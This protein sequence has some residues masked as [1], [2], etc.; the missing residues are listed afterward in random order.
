MMR[1]VPLNRAALH[2]SRLSAVGKGTDVTDT[3]PAVADD[4]ATTQKKK[5]T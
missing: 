4:H 3:A 2:L 5:L 1:A